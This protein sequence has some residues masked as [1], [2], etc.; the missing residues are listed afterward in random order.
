M[1]NISLSDAAHRSETPVFLTYLARDRAFKGI[2]P[3]RAAALGEAFGSGLKDALLNIDHRVIDI[4]GEQ[5]ALAA[6]AVL[7]VREA[8]AEFLLWLESL[9]AEIPASKA[10]RIARAWGKNGIEAVYNNPYLL[11]AIADFKVVDAIGRALGIDSRD[12]RRDV[13]ALEAT[14]MGDACLGI[15]STRI[16]L[17]G[18]Q[19]G[20]ERLLGRAIDPRSIDTAVRCGGAI[21][22]GADLQPP[23]TAY[24]EAECALLFQ[25]LAS[26]APAT[27]ITPDHVLD[28]LL[29]IYEKAQPF[30][31]T[32]PQKQA[33]RLAHRHRLLILAGYAGSGKTTVLRGVCETL[34]ATGRQPL[35]VTLSGRAA[36]RATEA[37]GRRA[38]TVARFLVEL[39]KSSDPLPP[40]IALI[41]DEASMLGLVEMWRVLRR[42]GDASLLLCGDPAQL[43]PVSPGIVFH[44]LAS[45]LNVQKQT[46]D[47]VHR[48][49]EA[50]GIPALAEVVRHGTIPELSAINGIQTGV[51]F[52]SCDRENLCDELLRIGLFLRSEGIDR[53]DLQI[54]AP[55][56]REI[57]LINGFFH[58]KRLAYD[59]VLWPGYGHIAEGEPVIFTENDLERGLTNGSL[60]RVQQID[61]AEI[62]VE[63]DG[64]EHRLRPEDGAK[65]QL[66]YAISVHKA[67][68]SQWSRVIVP[69]F[70]S[71]IL[72]RSLIYTALTRAQHQ[73]F[74][75][76]NWKAIQ[77]AVAKPSTSDRRFCGFSDWLDLARARHS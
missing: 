43:P 51:S 48:Q 61:Q 53:N 73:V 72:D 1:N 9:G 33:V 21:R 42:L 71:R 65:L 16:S 76:G 54:I 75:L 56:N 24:M 36:K 28:E 64:I 67:Q 6:A 23:G 34:E 55:T 69:I 18:A 5:A 32:D 10:I 8:E 44:S 38:I 41:A 27:G 66:A 11:L 39:D 20:A 30:R 45:D 47:R 57:G 49:D 29:N 15:G 26:E 46:L 22:L 3:K 70:S 7:E 17:K 31:L 40:Q 62:I 77:E 14:L 19:R 68:G 63:L 58:R 52:T 4:V 35:I 37:T 25:K 12:I 13:A 74:F 60:G 59:P 50:T 2:G